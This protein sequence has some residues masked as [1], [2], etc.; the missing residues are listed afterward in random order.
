M[1]KKLA[2]LCASLVACSCFVGCGSSGGKMDISNVV[3]PTYE[4]TDGLMITAYSGPTVENWSGVSRNVS[5]LTEEH[6]QKFAEA[7]FTGL[8]AVHEGGW[9]GGS[10]VYEKVRN[11]TKK[12]VEDALIALELCEKYDIKY[13]VRDWSFYEL[14]HYRDELGDIDEMDFYA[15]A[16]NTMRKW[17]KIPII[18]EMKFKIFESKFTIIE[19]EVGDY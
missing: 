16:M 19:V 4:E 3:I 7:G 10:T 5:T 14:T 2:L 6:M 11:T 15:E 8:L 17:D 13:Y 9:S 12:S 1:K 18:K